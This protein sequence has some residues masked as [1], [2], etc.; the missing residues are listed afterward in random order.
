MTPFAGRFYGRKTRRVQGRTHD[1][2]QK[3]NLSS[4][5]AQ[6]RRMQDR[7][8]PGP[9]ALRSSGRPRALVCGRTFQ[10]GRDARGQ[11]P[12]DRT[13]LTTAVHGRRLQRMILLTGA[14]AAMPSCL[15]CSQHG[16]QR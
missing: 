9:S 5:C 10:A 3:R 16:A 8:L 15:Q 6:R 12:S 2:P 14:P 7:V 11:P 1:Q 4:E 13:L